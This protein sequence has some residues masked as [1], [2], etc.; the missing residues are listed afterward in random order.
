MM[1]VNE[2]NKELRD[3]VAETLKAKGV[4]GKVQ[5]EIRASVFLALEEQDVFNDKSPFLNKAL[6]DFCKT[7]DGL[8]VLSLVREFLEFFNLEF[9]AMVFDPETHAGIDYSYEGR[10]KLATD[11]KLDSPS[12]K[13]PLLAQ[14]I[15]Q[16]KQS[17]VSHSSSGL[18]G[19][20]KRTVDSNSKDSQLN[21]D[22]SP[23]PCSMNGDSDGLTSSKKLIRTSPDY[24]VD[25][26]RKNGGTN[27]VENAREKAK[28]SDANPLTSLSNL[29]PLNVKMATFT[30]TK[31]NDLKSLI[32]FGLNSSV[33]NNSVSEG[34]KHSQS[35]RKD[36]SV[37][38]DS[39]IEEEIP[40]HNSNA[41]G[42]TAISDDNTVD[43][44][45]SKASGHGDYVEEV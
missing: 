38:E 34:D 21:N 26:P 42:T 35:R 17:D 4:L 31:G 13:L 14:V 22:V 2:E 12:A 36:D 9:T 18:N 43:V 32:D 45:I 24:H 23:E 20:G 25:L 11:L 40:S 33:E 15:S 5:A 16:S 8:K 30:N 41:S 37:S 27:R 28:S 19:D 29:P 10:N 44:S 1:P 7:S 3:L 6:K 39:E